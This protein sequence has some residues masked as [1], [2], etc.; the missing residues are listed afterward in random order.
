MD[1]LDTF[2]DGHGERADAFAPQVI[3]YSEM[4]VRA[5]IVAA[6]KACKEGK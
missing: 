4:A 2:Y 5:A 1:R 3:V 6:Q